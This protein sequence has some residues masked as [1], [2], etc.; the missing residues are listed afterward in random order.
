MNKS[1][2]G[3]AAGMILWAASAAA[4][5]RPHNVVLF[6]PDGLRAKMVTPANAPSMAT[7]R[8]EG[9]NFQNSH[10]MFPTFTMPN[11]SALATGHGLGDTG[12]FSNT[13]LTGYPVAPGGNTITPFLENDA[14]LGDTDQHFGGN[15]LDEVTLLEA[16]RAA[17]LST[18][19][20]GKVGP[21]LSS[22][23]RT[24]PA[25]Q[26]SSSMTRP[27]ARLAF[28]WRPR[29]PMQSRPRPCR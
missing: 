29:S 12:I 14:V 28:P 20:I 15:I 2:F 19:A 4:V 26:R 16:A 18:A 24:A 11:A 3:L 7:L 27:E 22:I 5:D 21:I 23:T 13:I 9:V 1:L 17:G 6:V 8:D 25:R 10:S